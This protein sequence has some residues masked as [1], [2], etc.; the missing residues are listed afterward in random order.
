MAKEPMP[1]MAFIFD[2]SECIE[3]TLMMRIVTFLLR[4]SRV[5]VL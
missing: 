5:T 3:L 2:F 4:F 1:Y